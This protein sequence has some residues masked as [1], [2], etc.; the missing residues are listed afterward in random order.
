MDLRC[1]IVAVAM[2]AAAACGGDDR[3]ASA[4]RPPAARRRPLPRPT[5][6]SSG[7]PDIVKVEITAP[8]RER[9]T[10]P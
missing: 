7:Y 9:S 10:S 2:L 3:L 5:P 8:G 6:P 4:A 1:A